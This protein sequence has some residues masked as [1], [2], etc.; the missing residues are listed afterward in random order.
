MGYNIVDRSGTPLPQSQLTTP[1]ST[2]KDIVQLDATPFQLDH[3]LLR[4]FPNFQSFEPWD[5]EG[6]PTVTNNIL[7]SQL[8]KWCP[9]VSSICVYEEPLISSCC[10]EVFVKGLTAVE[11]V[12]DELTEESVE[13]ILLHKDTLT[14]ILLKDG[15]YSDEDNGDEED[16]DF[17]TI[18]G[19]DL[20]GFPQECAQLRSF[21]V[22]CYKLDM[23]KVVKGEWACKN[24]STL[25]I[26]VNGLDTK[27]KIHKTI[28]LRR[29]G[30]RRR[31]QE[32]VGGVPMVMEKEEGEVDL[33]LEI[34][35]AR[36][37]LKFDK[38]WWVWVGEGETWTPF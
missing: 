12:F 8:Q 33:P 21:E 35:V 32:E 34:C 20:M 26:K 14:S 36:H 10:R 2:I 30:R 29:E 15:A 28:A 24:L 31:W 1:R 5:F 38:L 7:R 4:F 11:F 6:E 25:R 23:D 18:S 37:L 3:C 22:D 16:E 27:E 9:L 19:E 13:T 17:E